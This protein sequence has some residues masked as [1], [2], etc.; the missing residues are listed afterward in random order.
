MHHSGFDLL[1]GQA[2]DSK[3]SDSKG[4][5]RNSGLD[6]LAGQFLD[7]ELSDSK[8]GV[9]NSGLDQLAGQVL[10]S[11]LSDSRINGGAPPLLDRGFV[12][13]V[14]ATLTFGQRKWQRRW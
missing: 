10:G 12:P 7:S 13:T 1:A 5:G 9:H 8:D 4:G 3:L 11:E 14:Q 2:L 6:Q